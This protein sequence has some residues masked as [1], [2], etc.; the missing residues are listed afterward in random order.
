MV[1]QVLTHT[2]VQSSI[3]QCS[4]GQYYWTREEG[5][6]DVIIN[7][8]L[9]TVEA[10][11]TEALWTRPTVFLRGFIGR[12]RTSMKNWRATVTADADGRVSGW[13]GRDDRSG[14]YNKLAGI[15]YAPDLYKAAA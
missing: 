1:M 5:T 14:R 2:F 3:E 8:K 7:G 10:S 12:Y 9:I 15:S 11:R 6:V 13:F 4:A